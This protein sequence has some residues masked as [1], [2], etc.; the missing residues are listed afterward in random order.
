VGNERVAERA[1]DDTRPS[2][3]LRLDGGGGAHVRLRVETN[4][5]PSEDLPNGSNQRRIQ[6]LGRQTPVTVKALDAGVFLN[7]GTMDMG[8]D[9]YGPDGTYGDAVPTG[10]TTLYG[11]LHDSLSILRNRLEWMASALRPV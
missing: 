7:D 3:L 4:P 10:D 2:K 11:D 9:G 1:A 5:E 8:I 6:M